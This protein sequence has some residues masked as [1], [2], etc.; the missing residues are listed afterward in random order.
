MI[1]PANRII[2][3]CESKKNVSE[4]HEFSRRIQKLYLY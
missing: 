2:D 1:F 3:W 4:M